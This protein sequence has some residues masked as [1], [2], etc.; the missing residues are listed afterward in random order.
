MFPGR[1]TCVEVSQQLL[2][3]VLGCERDGCDG[4]RGVYVRCERG[5]R[6]GVRGGVCDDVRGV[7][8]MV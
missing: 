3:F 1:Y 4:T 8:V 5:F 7:V 2:Y 6:D